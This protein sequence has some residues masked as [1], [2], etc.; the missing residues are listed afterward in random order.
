MFKQLYLRAVVGIGAATLA[1][2]SAPA[3]IIET[4]SVSNTYSYFFPPDGAEMDE[5]LG[6]PREQMFIGSSSPVSELGIDYVG[7]AGA[8]SFFFLHNNYCVGTCVTNSSTTITFTVTN[9]G[10]DAVALR[11]DSFI[12]PGHLATIGTGP[13]SRGGFSFEVTQRPP[14]DEAMREELYS[15][16]G[17]VNSEEIFVQTSNGVEFNNFSD[18]LIGDSR[19]VDWSTTALNLDIG[20]LAAGATTIIEYRALYSVFSSEP[21]DDLTACSGLQVVFGDPRNNGTILSRMASFAAFADD[22]SVPI[23][24]REYD[25]VEIPYA[26]NLADSPF[27][28]L[29]PAQGPVSYSV[30]FIPGSTAAVPEPATWATLICGFGL[31]GSTLR[32]RARVQ[33]A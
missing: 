11:F 10:P 28:D 6:S 24:N 31:I 1:A 13:G 16:F 17:N 18:Q 29:P 22:S 8:G 23:I 21:C 9:D 5:L 19:I 32:R 2:G 12:T 33:A 14:G 4:V 7:E 25:A 30:D 27:P 26:I 15:A 20:T 3:A